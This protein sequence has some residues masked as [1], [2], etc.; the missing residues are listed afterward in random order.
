MPPEEMETIAQQTEVALYSYLCDAT[1]LSIGEY[2]E[3]IAESGLKIVD[4]QAYHTSRKLTPEQA[5]FE[6]RFACENVPETYGK[7]TPSFEEVWTR[8]GADIEEH[9][10]GHISKVLLMITRKGESA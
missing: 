5:R 4:R 6:I 1:W 8:F 2:E 10:L 9:G 3:I 7:H